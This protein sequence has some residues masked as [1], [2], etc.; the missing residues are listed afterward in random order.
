MKEILH[1]RAL[2]G[3]IPQDLINAFCC[4]EAI[5]GVDCDKSFTAHRD[6]TQQYKRPS[7]EGC[8]DLSLQGESGSE[9][10][11][12][13]SCLSNKKSATDVYLSSEIIKD[14]FHLS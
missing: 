3:K 6:F 13:L 14:Y 2:H 5:S 7:E 11:N 4:N 12:Y 9:D 10:C 1:L 8:T